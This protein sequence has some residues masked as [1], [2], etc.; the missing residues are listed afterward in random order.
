MAP[1]R[2][3]KPAKQAKKVYDY[4]GLEKGMK[5]QAEADGVFYSA[6]IVNVSKAKNRTNAPVKVHFAGYGDDWDSWVSGDR[7]R[8]KALKSGAPAEAKTTKKKDEKKA[9]DK[10]EKTRDARPRTVL[11]IVNYKS[12]AGKEKAFDTAMQG[13]IED[14]KK[15]DGWIVV[16]YTFPKPG[17]VTFV[18]LFKSQE[19]CDHYRKNLR[20]GMFEK[21]KDVMDSSHEDF[22]KGS[23]PLTRSFRNRD[24]VL[25]D[26]SILRVWMY[27]CKEGK[28]A[29]FAKLVV[30]LSGEVRKDVPGVA[31][32]AAGMSS[33]REC[34]VAFVWENKEKLE[35]YR[36]PGGAREKFMERLAPIK[37]KTLFHEEG[38]LQ[39]L[40]REARYYP[41]T[42]QAAWDNHFAA[43]GAQ[44]LEKIMLDYDDDSV[45]KVFNNVGD[46]KTEHKG[47][48]A[49]REMFTGLFKDL[50]DLKTLSAPVCDV[51]EEGKSVFLC[52]K[53]PGCKYETATDTFLFRKVRGQVKIS[54]Q[55]IVITKK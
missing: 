3:A 55:N 27:S 2:E 50:P 29:D 34:F 12:K 38:P 36:A 13:V 35:A 22:Y 41:K 28:E 31:W 39:S 10:N 11:R 21:V 30:E 33:P 16:H 15:E 45:A 23:G 1:R 49:I 40:S 44:D 54:R 37:D 47:T 24:A 42:V 8:S 43:F 17:T 18:M 46:A 48:A 26:K 19:A 20:E 25:D 51:D 53:C 14:F 6:E 9:G 52:W 5:C 32:L 7:L 4:S